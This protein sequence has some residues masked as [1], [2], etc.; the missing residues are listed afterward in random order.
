MKTRHSTIAYAVST[1]IA[2][3]LVMS[4]G[5]FGEDTQATTSGKHPGTIKR[6]LRKIRHP[7]KK[8]NVDTNKVSDASAK[9]SKTD[10]S[11]PQSATEQASQQAAATTNAAAEK[12][13][14]TEHSAIIETQQGK[15]AMPNVNDTST[16]RAANDVP[17]VN[18]KPGDLATP[19]LDEEPIHGFH[20]IKRIMRPV[21]NLAKQSVILGQNIMRL[22][23]PIA[24]LQPSML[25]L[26]NEMGRVENRMGSVQGTVGSMQGTLGR[27]NSG[28]G[29]VR[30]DMRA[31][32]GD[33]T[34]VRGDLGGM[35]RDI[36]SLEKPIQELRDPLREV[37]KP[38]ST[39]NEQLAK[40]DSSLT[41]LKT[42][43]GTVLASI[44]VAAALICF[45]IPLAAFMVYKNRRKLFPGTHEHD[46]PVVH[47]A[48]TVAVKPENIEP[49]Q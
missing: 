32:R 37:S 20:P 41:D 8:V 29:G 48:D 42:L 14:R 10:S 6:V 4:T 36:A 25:G 17:G 24:S 34:G 21:E 18:A 9:T 22:E 13:G 47:P 19:I 43:L 16:A 49:K 39:I 30:T 45:G 40:V 35:R 33:I 27:V 38:V 31:V 7:F 44:Y 12:S 5:A 2:F 11:D 26:K 15:V 46:M 1:S 3:S 23:A 28:V